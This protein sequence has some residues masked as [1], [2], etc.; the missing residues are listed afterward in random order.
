MNRR[1]MN[2]AAGKTFR[3]SVFF[4]LLL[5]FLCILMIPVAVG[6]LLYSK[7]EQAL[8]DHANESNQ[9]LLEQ[10]R[11]SIDSRINEVDQ[12]AVQ[13]ALNPTLQLLLYGEERKESFDEY[14]YIELIN[15][16]RRY[17][18]VSPIIDDYYVYLQET[19]TIITPSVKTDSRTFYH[20]IHNYQYRD[21]KNMTSLLTRF[22]MKT[23]LP[24]EPVQYSQKQRNM[25]TFVQSLPMGEQDNVRGALV[26]MIDESDVLGLLN[27][28][29]HGSTDFYILNEHQELLSATAPDPGALQGIVPRLGGG[30]GNVETD[31][32]GRRMMVS[33]TRSLP[34]GWTYISVIPKEIVLSQVRETQ[35][36]ALLLILV[37]LIAGLAGSYY[38]AT[39]NYH[40]I[41][42]LIQAITAS[43]NTA[44][45]NFANEFAF[46]R[47]ELIHS[48]DEEHKMRRQLARQSPLIRSDFIA[49]LIKGYVDTKSLTG[50]D[51]DFMGVCL[52]HEYHGVM[53]IQIDDCHRFI[54][55]DT[56]REWT[57]IRFILINLSKELLGDCGYAIEMERDRIGILLN[58][59]AAFLDT[60]EGGIQAF[61]AAL[62]TQV[63]QR[64]RTRITIALS[65]LRHGLHEIAEAYGEALMALDGKLLQDEGAVIYY[66]EMEQAE[67][68]YFYYPLETESQLIN[69]AKSGDYDSVAKLLDHIFEVNMQKRSM[70]SEM[71]R[72]LLFDLTSTVLKLFQ[73]LNVDEK[74]FLEGEPDLMKY[75][76][77]LG[78]AESIQA[79]LKQMY[80]AVCSKVESE[81]T[82]HS[83]R[84]Y[85]KIQ[86]YVMAHYTSNAIS[87]TSIADHCGLNPSYLS[88]FFKKQSGQNITD[89]IIALRI[90]LAKTYLEE[91][92]WTVTQ[93]AQ[94]V[95]Y[96]N[97]IGLIRVFK[98]IEGITPGKYK[99]LQARLT[100]PV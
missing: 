77:R 100:D 23:Y 67:P 71:R 65:G 15:G 78:T 43:K 61:V 44:G 11:L 91:G 13:V 36:L 8:I 18:N 62:K 76:A 31:I 25:I 33:Y 2:P 83:E 64:F 93:I 7:M 97:D 35:A 57:L 38:L 59:P 56:E 55:E 58:H 29:E 42:Q 24:V 72:H 51:F 6:S 60:G 30:Q 28:G 85:R 52:K 69:Y 41:R 32:D 27:N 92:E 66:E 98:K 86:D 37:C 22:H 5:S 48:I 47:H 80:A 4:K 70:S 74:P 16:F 10:A 94:K 40:P 45:R 96:T 1:K 21:E 53:L 39:K 90:K 50:R 89:Y 68:A 54:E 34:N 73:A 75:M 79:K 14:N 63:E 3:R 26:V 88:S 87:L 9:A 81:K 12:L 46:I 17:R 82:D 49:R 84:L 20:S 19:G 95:G 99:E